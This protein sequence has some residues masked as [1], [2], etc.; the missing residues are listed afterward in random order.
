METIMEDNRNITCSIS[1]VNIDIIKKRGR[2]PTY[3]TQ[4]KKE[5]RRNEKL[6]YYKKYYSQHKEQMKKQSSL[7]FKNRIIQLND[8]VENLFEKLKSYEK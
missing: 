5:K 3:D 1:E 8:K 2:K 4:E 6:E 7:A